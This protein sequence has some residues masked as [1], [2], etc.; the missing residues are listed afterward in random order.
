MS[1]NSP[2]GSWFEALTGFA[3]ADAATVRSQLTLEGAELVS[4]VNRRRIGVGSLS[5]PS[6]HELRSATPD[7]GPGAVVEVVGDARALHA[8]PANA[9]ALFQVASQFN[10]LEMVGPER[11][12]E[13]GVSIYEHDRTQGPACAIACGG[14]TI[15]RN[16]F[17]PVGDQ[18]GQ[19]ADRQIDCLAGLGSVLGHDPSSPGT[20]LWSMENGYCLATP[21]GLS[22]IRAVLDAASDGEREF[23][24]GLLEVGVHA[25]VEVTI[26]GAGHAVTQVFGS[27]LPVAYS[28]LSTSAWEPFA[29]LVL[30]ASYEATLRAAHRN[31][32]STGN[33]MVFLTRL[34]GGVFGNE[35]AWIDAAIDRA[36]SL[37]GA[38]LDL[39][40]VQHG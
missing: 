33:P 38:G 5:T 2:S 1:S 31:L 6:L 4:S 35:P 8:D 13:A 23:F 39:R 11:T 32:A 10:L 28:E 9:G 14:G 27:A 34:G 29:R 21:R 30:D 16:W 19:S 36:C 26:D 17:V 3:E 18:L 25:D 7:T 12:P 37:V 15:Y 24:A 40:L 20:M 22:R